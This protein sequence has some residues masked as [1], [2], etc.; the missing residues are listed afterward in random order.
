MLD[1]TKPVQTRD[2]RPVRIYRTDGSGIRPIH[3][4]IKN[5]EGHEYVAQWYANGRHYGDTI[6]SSCDLVNVPV[7]HTVW[8]N[9][10]SFFQ[11]VYLYPTKSEAD[12]RAGADRIA[13]VPITFTEG[14]GL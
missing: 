3:G 14:E 4:A 9:V 2:G 8:V 10:Y 11:V 1:L 13:C 6:K 5:S 7:R 12:Q